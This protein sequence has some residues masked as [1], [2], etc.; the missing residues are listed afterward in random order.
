[1]IARCTT[2]LFAVAT[3]LLFSAVAFSQRTTPVKVGL[4]GATGLN[5]NVTKTGA[6]LGFD[7]ADG[8]ITKQLRMKRNGSFET[9]GTF[10]RSGPGPIRID[11]QPQARS[12]I[13]KGKVTDK[14]MT[15]TVSDA[16][17]GEKITTQTL[18]FGQSGRIHRCL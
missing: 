1:M 13:Y 15:L 3:L 9:A 11:A 4:W 2:S 10:T 12:V 8:E 7:C 5:M 18:T 14:T 6:T 17:T 16:A